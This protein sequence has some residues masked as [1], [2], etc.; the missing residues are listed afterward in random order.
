MLPF[1]EYRRTSLWLESIRAWLIFVQRECKSQVS[2]GTTP[3]ST[4]RQLVGLP[5]HRRGPGLAA[6]ALISCRISPD[7]PSGRSAGGRR[8]PAPPAAPP[9]NFANHLPLRLIVHVD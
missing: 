7:D 1:V 2:C 5:A 3:D 9:R 4:A 6:P 8:Q